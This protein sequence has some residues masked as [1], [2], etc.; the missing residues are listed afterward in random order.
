MLVYQKLKL[1]AAVAFF[2]S[3]ALLQLIACHKVND[4]VPADSESNKIAGIDKP[5]LGK[6]NIILILGD[7]IGYE[8]PA[9]TGGQSY[10]TPN[11][12]ALS[13]KG[14]Q[15]TNCYSMPM[16]TPSRF[17]MM[18]GKYNNRNYYGDSW[19]NLDLSQRT[20]ANM[21]HDGGY[22]TCIAGKWQLNGGD[23]SIHIFGF[24]KYS[25][26]N[27]YK[28]A[29]DNEDDEGLSIYKDPVILQNGAYLPDAFTKGKYGED[30][31][32]DFLFNFIDSNKSKSKPFFAVWTPNLCHAPFSPTPDDP[33][34]A[35][36]VPKTKGNKANSDTTYFKSMIKYFDKE[37]GML[38]TKLQSSSALS[39]TIVLIAIGDNG[40]DGKIHSRYKGKSYVG[41][42]GHTYYR[43][44]HVP[45][46]AYCPG[47]IA[48]QVN[49]N[50]IDFTDILPTLA[51]L[52]KINTPTNYG[53]LDG[54]SFSAQLL[55]NSYT[56][57]TSCFGYYDVNRNGPDNI[58]PA[59]YAFDYTYK[60]YEDSS[61]RFYNYISDMNEQKN[62]QTK[63]MTPAEKKADSTLDLVIRKYTK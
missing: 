22:T 18:T 26:T 31:N 37:V 60:L 24:D 15:F 7:D 39:N 16:C 43:G 13:K 51:G 56:A 49:N 41:G 32:R 17:E 57:R 46:L 2:L 11:L 29:D 6:P 34:F 54:Q 58:K 5:A 45:F 35:A 21:L 47:K 23:N 33:Q 1:K 50:L 52:A 19:G 10:Q 12:D 8:V 55:G 25:V 59:I 48:S 30:I 28:V 61:T 44:I 63:N 53:V 38:I 14:M 62:I 42:K 40:T 4:A 36:W 3:V 27:P 20:I 9:Y